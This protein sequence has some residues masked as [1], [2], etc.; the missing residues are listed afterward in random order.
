[1]NK[2]ERNKIVISF[3]NTTKDE[4]IYKYYNA[5]EEKSVFIKEILYVYMNNQNK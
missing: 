5:K 1:M 4:A 3:K 2:K